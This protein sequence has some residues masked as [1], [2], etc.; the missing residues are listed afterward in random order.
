MPHN[1]SHFMVATADF[2]PGLYEL[3]DGI[4]MCSINQW[5]EAPLPPLFV[6]NANEARADA[7]YPEYTGTRDEIFGG[8]VLDKLIVGLVEQQHGY[9]NH[10]GWALST[11][12]IV[13]GVRPFFAWCGDWLVAVAA[14]KI[15]QQP[16]YW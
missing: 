2:A 8:W 10:I 3:H 14:P 13:P 12:D 7:R 11:V 5:N 4:I 9:P 6:G 15:R 1:V 16:R